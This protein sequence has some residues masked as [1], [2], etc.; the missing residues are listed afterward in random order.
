MCSSDLDAAREIRSL[1][2][3]V[4]IAFISNSSDYA[5]DSYSVKA[6]DYIIKPI[7]RGRLAT[8]LDN[9]SKAQKK[10]GDIVLFRNDAEYRKIH[11]D[12]IIFAEIS[13]KILTVHKKDGSAFTCRMA[14]RNA[15][16]LL[17]PSGVFVRTHRAFIVNVAHIV[18]ITP[19]YADMEGGFSVPISRNYL[20]D[21]R[22]AFLTYSLGG[23]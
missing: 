6:A 19:S 15:E 4:K 11:A 13:G 20:H 18:G 21:V 9:I 23:L 7:D 5:V 10:R 8:L 22:R 3:D 12:D 2:P 16:E 1:D 17:A 14:I